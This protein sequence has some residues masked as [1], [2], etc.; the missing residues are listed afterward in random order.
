MEMNIDILRILRS[1][2]VLGVR[3]NIF[4]LHYF[5]SHKSEKR[6]KK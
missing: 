4:L 1:E 3:G 6:K 5:V 2:G